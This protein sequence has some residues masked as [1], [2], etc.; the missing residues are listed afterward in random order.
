M[1][2]IPHG[3]RPISNQLTE[4]SESPSAVPGGNNFDIGRVPIKALAKIANEFRSVVEATIPDKNLSGGKTI[5]L[6]RAA[7][8]RKRMKRAAS[9]PSDG[10]R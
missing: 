10:S 1:S 8:F 7:R 6:R 2:G 3:K 5:G 4:P 9:S